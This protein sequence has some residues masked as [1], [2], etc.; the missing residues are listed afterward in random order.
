[1]LC[2]GA[3]G[4]AVRFATLEATI[5]PEGPETE[6]E[7]VLEWKAKRG[8]VKK[9][10]S[11]RLAASAEPTTISVIPRFK[12]LEHTDYTLVLRAWWHGADEAF[13][14]TAFETP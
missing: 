7:V 14:R 6:Y 1:L 11:G 2:V 3:L 4:L 10:R 8:E 5:N 9:V 13:E 12:L